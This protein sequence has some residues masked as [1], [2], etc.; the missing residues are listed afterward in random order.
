MKFFCDRET[1]RHYVAPLVGAWIEIGDQ[2]RG[3]IC[4][5]VAPLVGARI[6]IVIEENG[7]IEVMSLPLWERG[8]KCTHPVLTAILTIRS[9]PLWE[10]GL[11]SQLVF[12][13]CHLIIVA[14]LEGARIEILYMPY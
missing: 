14:P 10:R 2:N 6:E 4:K 11:K 1:A 13:F 3:G 9:L 7:G 12:C 8:L 5:I